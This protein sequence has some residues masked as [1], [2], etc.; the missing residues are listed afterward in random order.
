M[1]KSLGPIGN[2]GMFLLRLLPAAPVVRWSPRE[3]DAGWYRLL[4]CPPR[5]EVRPRQVLGRV[6]IVVNQAAQGQDFIWRFLDPAKL[7]L[8]EEFE[9]LGVAFV[10]IVPRPQFLW[11]VRPWASGIGE[12]LGLWIVRVGI[13]IKIPL[14][15][16][17]RLAR[18]ADQP[19]DVIDRLVV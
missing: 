2:P 7:A 19:L 13:D 9:G 10:H 1:A 4:R 15:D 17:N 16:G 5:G 11:A 12:R 8:S 14:M 3:C 6:V 18:L